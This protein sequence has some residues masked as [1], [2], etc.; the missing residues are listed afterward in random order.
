MGK[1]NKVVV[2][3]KTKTGKTAIINKVIYPESNMVGAV[4]VTKFLCQDHYYKDNATHVKMLHGF[5]VT[6]SLPHHRRLLHGTH[7]ERPD[8][9]TQRTG[10]GTSLFLR[11]SRIGEFS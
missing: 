3:G 2:F 8:E 9:W 4:S 11:H 10:E 5:C 6:G 7:R 1:V